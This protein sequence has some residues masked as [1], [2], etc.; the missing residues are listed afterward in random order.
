MVDNETWDL[1]AICGQLL[2]SVPWHWQSTR[3][4]TCKTLDLPEWIMWNSHLS[5]YSKVCKNMQNYCQTHRK[6]EHLPWPRPS[7]QVSQSLQSHVCTAQRRQNER[8]EFGVFE[9]IQQSNLE[10]NQNHM[11]SCVGIFEKDRWL[12]R[13]WVCNGVYV[14]VCGCDWTCW[15]VAWHDEMRRTRLS[16]RQRDVTLCSVVFFTSQCFASVLISRKI[17][18]Q[19]HAMCS[20]LTL[21]NLTYLTQPILETRSLG[22]YCYSIL[23]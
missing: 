19:C 6:S 12:W 14:C 10:Q 15:D 8:K 7:L 20:G 1:T 4:E 22:C 9:K 11:N 23:L 17:V 21:Y 18:R 5:K 13:L 3:T 2:R 16:W